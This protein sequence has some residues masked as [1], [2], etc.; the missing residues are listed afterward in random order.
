MGQLVVQPSRLHAQA[1]RLHHNK[2]KLI[3]YRVAEFVRIRIHPNSGEFGYGPRCDM[4]DQT[5][6][7]V[8]A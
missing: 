5:L 4:I 8:L 7:A 6:T 1:G 2:G 3:H